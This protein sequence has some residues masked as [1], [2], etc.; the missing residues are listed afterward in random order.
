MYC[1]YNTIHAGG[2]IV[3]QLPQH[4]P[5]LRPRFCGP[6]TPNGIP[7]TF[8]ALLGY[9]NQPAIRMPDTIT[10]QDLGEN[11][12]SPNYRTYLPNVYQ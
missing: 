4:K 10:K 9:F 2:H 11:R 8:A 5:I 6:P 7:E 3:T 12:L 1:M